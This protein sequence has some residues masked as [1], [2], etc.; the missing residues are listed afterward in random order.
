MASQSVVGPSTA[1]GARGAV[2]GV[3]SDGTSHRSVSASNVKGPLSELI[4]DDSNVVNADNVTDDD[5][6]TVVYEQLLD[7][8]T[9]VTTS[10]SC[11]RLVS[12]EGLILLTLGRLPRGKTALASRLWPHLYQFQQRYARHNCR[13]QPL[14]WHWKPATETKL[15][16]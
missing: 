16:P 5:I 10:R 7:P 6:T 13:P 11:S 4:V 2:G 12:L 15:W 3:V 14:N 9:P 8:R 1:D